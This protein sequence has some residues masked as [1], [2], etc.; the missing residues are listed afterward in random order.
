MKIAL[1]STRL[2]ILAWTRRQTDVINSGASF[3]Q[4]AKKIGTK[5]AQ[6]AIRSSMTIGTSFN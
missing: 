2:W 5:Y 3:R 6:S 1:K 4:T